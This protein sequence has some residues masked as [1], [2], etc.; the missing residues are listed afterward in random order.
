MLRLAIN[1]D[2][3]NEMDGQDGGAKQEDSDKKVDILDPKQEMDE[4]QKPTEDEQ[5]P[6]NDGEIIIFHFLL[7]RIFAY[8]NFPGFFSFS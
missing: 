4:A 3:T 7:F 2:E 1:D 6:V 8:M 5:L